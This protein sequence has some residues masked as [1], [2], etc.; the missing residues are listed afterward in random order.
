M[1]DFAAIQL[2]PVGDKY[3]IMYYDEEQRNNF[4]R[5]G[6]VDDEMIC[7]EYNIPEGFELANVF[8]DLKADGK[9]KVKVNIIE[10]D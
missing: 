6:T 9:I 4:L 2:V 1:E 8:I 5:Y 7:T 3:L 10:K